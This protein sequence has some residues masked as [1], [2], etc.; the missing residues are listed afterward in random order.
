MPST[1]TFRCEGE[2]GND[3]IISLIAKKAYFR[4]LPQPPVQCIRKH[5]YDGI[6]K[7]KKYVLIGN[8]FSEI[9]ITFTLFLF[10]LIFT[11]HNR[12]ISV[13]AGYNRTE[14]VW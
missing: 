10:F 11:F 13:F 1:E 2:I 9:H 5:Y 8:G 6:L 7:F 4:F 12:Q 14:I 3:K